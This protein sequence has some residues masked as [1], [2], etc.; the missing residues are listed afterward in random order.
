MLFL[1]S[2]SHA[3][4]H[5]TVTYFTIF[6]FSYSQPFQTIYVHNPICSDA[7]RWQWE[8]LPW[9]STS[10]L[11]RSANELVFLFPF[12]AMQGPDSQLEI[13]SNVTS[14]K[15]LFC[16]GAWCVYRQWSGPVRSNRHAPSLATSWRFWIPWSPAKVMLSG[17]WG[18]LNTWE[19]MHRGKGFPRSWAGRETT[20]KHGQVACVA[21]AWRP[22]GNT[23]EQRV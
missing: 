12:S 19:K 1:E 17:P 2:L 4:S 3:L 22:K 14:D 15:H 10:A 7:L 8:T 11:N 16:W 6:F 20:L 13:K 23:L 5:S 9:T 21:S 18:I